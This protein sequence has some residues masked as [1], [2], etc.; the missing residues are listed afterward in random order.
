MEDTGGGTVLDNILEA[1][2]FGKGW[3]RGDWDAA[4]GYQTC[5]HLLRL[6]A[7]GLGAPRLR[8]APVGDTGGPLLPDISGEGGGSHLGEEAD[9]QV[10]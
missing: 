3:H 4:S 9:G 5:Q 1:C 7:P 6:R 10:I 8:G 2:G